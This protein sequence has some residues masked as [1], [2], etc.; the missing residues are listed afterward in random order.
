MEVYFVNI[1]ADGKH[2]VH[3]FGCPLLKANNREFLGLF[4]NIGEA[5]NRA[6]LKLSDTVVCTHCCSEYSESI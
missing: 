6:L 2:I 5:L 4:I 3:K 1:N